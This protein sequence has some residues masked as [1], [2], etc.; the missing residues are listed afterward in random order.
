MYEY[1]DYLTEQVPAVWIPGFPIRLFEV[2]KNPRGVEP[3]NPYGVID[4]KTGT[5]SRTEAQK[6]EAQKTEAPGAG[7]PAGDSPA[8]RLRGLL[9]GCVL[10]RFAAA[11]MANSVTSSM[12]Q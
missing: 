2:A 12:H 6:T 9:E 3:V 5:T 10:A 7:A 1:Q 4:P 8:G 11:A